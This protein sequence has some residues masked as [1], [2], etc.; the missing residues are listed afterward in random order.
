MD[1]LT[2][3]WLYWSSWTSTL[4]TSQSR[5]RIDTGTIHGVVEDFEGQDRRWVS[6]L[7]VVIELLVHFQRQNYREN[8]KRTNEL[9]NGMFT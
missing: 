8:I 2:F 9:L 6:R 3:H 5:N 1:W 7:P 4:V